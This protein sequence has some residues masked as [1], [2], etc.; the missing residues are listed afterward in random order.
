MIDDDIKRKKTYARM[1]LGCSYWMI[2]MKIIS[3]TPTPGERSNVLDFKRGT[4]YRPISGLTVLCLEQM[5]AI[6]Q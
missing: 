6:R 5:R 3:V 4:G 2:P 1:L